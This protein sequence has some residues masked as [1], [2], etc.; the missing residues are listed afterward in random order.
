MNEERRR[1]FWTEPHAWLAPG[2]VA[3]AAVSIQP[4][5]EFPILDDFD[6]SA[7]VDD[8]RRH[9]EIRLSDWPSMTLI[10]QVLWGAGFSAAL[11][12]THLALRISTLVLLAVGAVAA[13]CW[14]RGRQSPR[15]GSAFAASA[16]ALSPQT[17]YFGCTFMTDIPGLALMLVSLWA[18]AV[19]MSNEKAAPT[20]A[21]SVVSSVAYL[22]RQTAV[23][24]A[25]AT[26]IVEA[27]RGRFRHAFLVLA[28]PIATA[29]LHRVW[30]VDHGVPHH[31]TIPMIDPS[32]L[33]DRWLMIERLARIIVTT[34]L[35]LLPAAALWMGRFST[36]DRS[37]KC[38]GLVATAAS[39]AAAVF[40]SPFRPYDN[41][42]VFDCGLGG[43][44]SLNRIDR[45]EGA[46][47]FAFGR[48]WSLFRIVCSSIA[49]ASLGVCAAVVVQSWRNQWSPAGRQLALSIA[50]CTLFA[51]ISG[52][53]Y[54]R[55]LIPVWSLGMLAL[56]LVAPKPTKAAWAV[57][58]IVA[59]IGVA[60][61]Q[62]YFCRFRT[63]WAA[64]EEFKRNGAP[65][66][67]IDGGMEFAALHRFNPFY[68]GKPE[69]VRPF[70]NAKSEFERS[71]LIRPMVLDPFSP[72]RIRL[73]YA[74]SYGDDGEIIV[75]KLVY[76][77]WVRR[78]SVFMLKRKPR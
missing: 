1:P 49:A 68:R 22:F 28:L 17:L 41:M 47:F 53:F 9:G 54:E 66:E 72:W 24:P 38:V 75:K 51:L 48:R 52:S 70:L 12:G 6:Y 73:P 36:L 55:Y 34:G 26:A 74:V 31:A 20:I 62:D 42:T 11:G 40:Y 64:L 71:D 69:R 76:T 13:Y 27:L 35:Y 29:V 18:C 50:G 44:C 65:A 16:I 21:A 77:S 19:G 39:V 67:A 2:L 25:I 59:L 15:S 58:L 7:T 30:L 45:L 78:G 8:L 33:A 63:V 3:V 61:S 23:I 43:D 46:E 57:S 37:A 60:G 5:G 56:T 14:M 32:L 4:T 10:G